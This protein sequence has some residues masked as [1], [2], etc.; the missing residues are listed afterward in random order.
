MNVPYGFIKT[1]QQREEQSYGWKEDWLKVVTEEKESRDLKFP[2][3]FGID[4]F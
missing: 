3:G 1:R 4:E 2:T